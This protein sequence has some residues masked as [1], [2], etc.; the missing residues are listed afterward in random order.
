MAGSGSYFV[1]EHLLRYLNVRVPRDYDTVPLGLF[2]GLLLIWIMPWSAFLYNAVAA[3]EWRATLAASP[4]LKGLKWLQSRINPTNVA[5]SLTPEE[6][7]RLFLALWAAIPLVFFSFSTRQEY[8]VLPAIP[9]LLLLIAAW[10]NDE[11]D[12]AES[13]TVPNPLVQSGQRI[14]VVLLVLGSLAS[15]ISGFFVLHSSAV[16]PNTDL[17]SLLHQNPGDYALSFGHFLDLNAQA[18]SAFRTPLP[19]HR[20]RP[21]RRNG[22]LQ[23][24]ATPR[25]TNPT[26]PTSPSPPEPSAS[27]S[28][29]T[30]ACR[31]SPLS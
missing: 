23:L 15:L 14:S 16:T 12:E 19:L 8:Y 11:A 17:A 1:N 2:W 18:M 20:H 29:L 3:V 10:L 13:F 27:C 7:T 6:S 9:P 24:E 30:S 4:L 22:F 25:P 5:A 21:L 31:S 26:S 28:P